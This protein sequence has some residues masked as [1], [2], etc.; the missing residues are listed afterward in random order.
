MDKDDE[1]VELSY[2]EKI[3]KKYL[4]LKE[5]IIEK[6]TKG[7]KILDTVKYVFASLFIIFTIIALVAS[8]QSGN[9][10]FWLILWIVII[11]TNIGI[12]MITDYCKYLVKNLVIPYLEDDD[13]IEFKKFDLF[14]DDILGENEEE[15][16]E[17]N[18]E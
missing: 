13:Q 6:Y 10:M 15:E 3:I 2:N 11:L 18:M 9:K 17:E 8:N 14:S 5:K 1:A 4:L 16:S 12:F 7:C